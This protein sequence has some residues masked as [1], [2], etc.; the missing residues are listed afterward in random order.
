MD[1]I[2]GMYARNYSLKIVVFLVIILMPFVLSVISF[3]KPISMN[4]LD[5]LENSDY[6]NNYIFIAGSY[7]YFEVRCPNESDKI[8]IIFF[9][10]NLFYEKQNI[11]PSNFYQWEYNN[12]AWKDVSGHDSQYIIPSEC[13]KEN[14]TFYFYIGLDN[15]ATPGHW[16]IKIIINDGEILS[17]NN[18]IAVIAQ[19]NLFLSSFIAFY[20]PRLM[21]KKSIFD[22]D[23]ICT[24]K[25]KIKV[26]LKENINQVVDKIINKLPTD[27]N[28][29]NAYKI[30]NKIPL[31]DKLYYKNEYEKSIVFNYQRSRL[32]NKLINTSFLSFKKNMGGE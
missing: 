1:L 15:K 27:N 8:C 3:S 22:I 31:N 29:E 17:C 11:S 30:E 4:N 6:S 16:N 28:K 26:V 20:Q 23:F 12:G 7:Q 18:C 19:F 24:D 9:H 13:K 10:D 25:K 2:D 21:D 32:K 14:D 5:Y